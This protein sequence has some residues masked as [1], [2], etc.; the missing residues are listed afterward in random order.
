M[1]VIIV[2]MKIVQK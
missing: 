2:N 1:D